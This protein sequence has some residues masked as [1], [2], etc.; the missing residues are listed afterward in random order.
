[1]SHIKSVKIRIDTGSWS[2]L[3]K[4][5]PTELASLDGTKSEMS[6]LCALLHTALRTR[7]PNS[8]G[9][10]LADYWAWLR[11]GPAIDDLPDLKLRAAWKDIDQHQK[12][13]LSDDLGMGFTTYLLSKVLNFK[14][15]ADTLHFANVA[16][17]GLY[18]FLD[19]KKNGKHKS[20]DFV[21]MDNAG[22]PKNISII[23]CKGSQ[24]S[25]AVLKNLMKSGIEQKG[26]LLPVAG[27]QANIKHRLVAG[28]LIPQSHQDFEATI[29]ICDPE[30]DDFNNA[31]AQ[32]SPER[33]ETAIVQIDL[34]KQFAL[35]NL[36]SIS[37]A[38]ATTN[39]QAQKQLSDV[40]QDEL[41]A[42][43]QVSSNS[44]HTFA[45]ELPLPDR[46][47]CFGLQVRRVRFTMT[48][49]D[50]LYETL[51]KT[52]DL[53]DTF[54]R[55][56]EQAKE[57]EWEEVSKETIATLTTPLGFNLTLEYLEQ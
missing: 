29:R 48:S 31:L 2:T 5:V 19:V 25:M 40:N 45:F 15:F 47:L 20:P 14:S 41:R 22:D 38:L 21:A 51:V 8:T 7:P 33:R 1:M 54:T 28:L 3:S 57:R 42:L 10:D 34:A 26:N 17:P 52:Q 4:V 30:F 50:G 53:E 49:P 9:I 55:Y 56:V 12:N 23:E 37:R 6:V 35:M 13:I 46:T 24:S 11:Y 43:T 44:E 16:H 32:I 36:S 27:S 18:N 39:T